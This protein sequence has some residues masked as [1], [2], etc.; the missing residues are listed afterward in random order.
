MSHSDGLVMVAQ[1]ARASEA[2]DQ[3]EHLL[4]LAKAKAW[5]SSANA[6]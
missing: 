6:G 3:L 2:A 5:L 1:H 4:V